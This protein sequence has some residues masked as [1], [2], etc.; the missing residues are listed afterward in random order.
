[1]PKQ[2]ME[3]VAK[4]S[5]VYISPD[6]FEV[7]PA[8][9]AAA[10]APQATDIYFAQLSYW[11]QQDVVDAVNHANR[12]SKSIKDSPVKH[13][14]SVR[15][16][17]QSGQ[18]GMGGAIG[19]PAFIAIPGQ[20]G[21][22]PDAAITPHKEASPTARVS[23]G[24]YDVFYFTV[25]ADVEAAKRGEFLRSLGFRKFITPLGVEVKAVDNA[26]E[27]AKGHAYGEKPMINLTIP[28][29]VLY[30]RKW[31]QPYLPGQ[32]KTALGIAAEAGAA[33]AAPAAPAGDQSH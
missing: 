1:M 18:P 7:Y 32:I 12:D 6:T 13:L 22:D 21:G 20:A 27:L 2:M 3:E 33:P 19:M 15:S 23:N 29:E 25:S 16:G 5:R 17:L 24:M 11:I 9:A 31:N 30:L 14:I 8:I 26:T 4:T 28:C 10:G